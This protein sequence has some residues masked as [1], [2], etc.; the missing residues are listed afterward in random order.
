MHQSEIHLVKYFISRE[1]SQDMQDK[2]NIK[3]DGRLPPA[4][5]PPIL[6]KMAF[7]WMKAFFS[8]KILF[9]QQIWNFFKFKKNSNFLQKTSQCRWKRDFQE[10][11]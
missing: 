4:S 5:P 1:L 6:L 10:I 11:I 8:K 7:K 2:S 3:K 9:L